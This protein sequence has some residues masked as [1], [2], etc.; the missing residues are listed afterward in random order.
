MAIPVI[1]PKQG[2]SVETCIITEWVK[3]K[4]DAV[5]KGDVLFT[6]ETDKA[7]FETEAEAEGILLDIFFA[8]GG[9]VPVLQ[10]VAVIGAA[11][12]SSDAFRPGG[13]PVV[14]SEISDSKISKSTE[15]ATEILKSEITSGKL[16]VSPRA[17][18]MA[19]KN[20][21]DLSKING[22]GPN[23]RIVASDIENASMQPAKIEASALQPVTSNLQPATPYTPPVA[24]TLFSNNDYTVNKISN[25]RKL[26]AKAMHESISNSA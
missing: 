6:Y 11:G 1:M 20:G 21:V 14:V 17:R 19:E 2:Q 7:S 8:D 25:I 10:N 22:S 5:K 4:G 24:S 9:E 26:I 15:P 3:K 16:K 18:V 23:G 12:E 13:A